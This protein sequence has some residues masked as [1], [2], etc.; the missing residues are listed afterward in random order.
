MITSLELQ[1]KLIQAGLVELVEFVPFQN[2]LE[3]REERPRLLVRDQA[4]E[5]PQGAFSA[6]L[7]R[8]IV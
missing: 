7:A 3:L 4:V 2:G 6:G 5:I 8:E 1:K